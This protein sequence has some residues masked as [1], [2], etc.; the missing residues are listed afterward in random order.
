MTFITTTLPYISGQP[1]VGHLF[2][3]VLGDSIARHYRMTKNPVLFNIGL[4]E[5]GLKIQQL[6]EQS[7][8]PIN[9][10]IGRSEQQW[11]MF[12]LTLG[13]K[14]D[15][16]YTTNAAHHHQN[17]HQIWN[18]LLAKG[19]IYKKKYSG[20][21][22]VGCESFKPTKDLVD[23]KCPDHPH[24]EL[25]EIEEEN[26]FF[27]LSKYKEALKE[28]VSKDS[29]FL[30]PA[31]LVPELVNLIDSVEDIS[32]S[33]NRSVVSHGVQVPDDETQTIYVWFDALLNYIFAAGYYDQYGT[34]QEALFKKNWVNVTQLCGPDNLRFQAVIFQGILKALDIPFTDKLLVHGTILDANGHKQ[35]KSL[36][37]VVDPNKQI[38]K[39]GVD[40]V[41]YYTLAGLSTYSNSNWSE[42]ELVD[43]Y[44]N[45]LAN[46]YGN[47]LSRV[48]HLIDTKNIDIITDIPEQDYQRFYK[49]N[50]SDLGKAWNSGNVNAVCQII[51]HMV[52]LGNGY[53]NE[54]EPW[55][56]EPAEQRLILSALYNLLDFVTDLYEPIIP[57]KVEEARALLKSKK[58]GILFP[59]FGI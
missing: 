6:A 47:L 5:N 33:R 25:Q 48:L 24:L 32:I 19:D 43:F 54:T 46:D 53:I 16:F 38:E 26:Y 28:L 58:K 41:R 29:S 2:E 31:K 1:H 49:G 9:N 23:G 14:Y 20:T 34:R 3:F 45:H 35:S 30:T 4:D 21:Y 8:I 15:N 56:K 7:G 27:R 51:N 36:G 57:N 18:K 13:I 59:K 40:A 11:I 17:V 52:K 39:Y 55:K 44:N 22:C 37:N 12:C 50:L 10:Y 42:I